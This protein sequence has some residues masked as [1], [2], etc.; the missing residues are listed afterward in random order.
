MEIR[1]SVSEDK[2]KHFLAMQKLEEYK[3]VKP[4]P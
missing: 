3:L 1:F 2:A 4:T